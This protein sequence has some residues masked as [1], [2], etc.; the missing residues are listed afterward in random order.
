MTIG[1]TQHG[2]FLTVFGRGVLLRGPSGIGK[3]A[4]ALELID[5]G[6]Q[7]V[8]DD[9]PEFT[10]NESSQIVGYC[11]AMLQDFLSV[12]GLGV[13]NVRCL[14]GAQAI[15]KRQALD[16]IIRFC[17]AE[18]TSLDV[19]EDR[20]A[21]NSNVVQLFEQQIPELTLII[22]K[23]NKLSPLW[24]ECAV[25]NQ[26][27]RHTGYCAA[28]DLTERLRAKLAMSPQEYAKCE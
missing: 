14:F 27:L 26:R 25:A 5:R 10:L 19:Y 9:V 21:G 7:L 20:L 3:S 24:I 16:L 8:A 23:G 28:S 13:L 2:V 6:H 18:E 11:P 1:L 17:Y 22:S 15:S 12:R 4:L